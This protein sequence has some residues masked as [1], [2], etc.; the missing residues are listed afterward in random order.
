MSDRTW[1]DFADESPELAEQGRRLFYQ[2]S[3][4]AS[5]FLATVALDHGPRV[6]PVFPVLA[7]GNLWLFIVKMS[8]KYADLVRSGKFALHT[9]PTAEGGEEFHIRGLANEIP[10]PALKAKVVEA[11]QGRQG[12]HDFEALFQCHLQSVLYTKWENWGSA[13]TWPVYSKWIA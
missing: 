11:T 4:I 10:D 12:G 5:G 7:D 6:H 2:G 9:M 1:A 8:L 13:E 3:E